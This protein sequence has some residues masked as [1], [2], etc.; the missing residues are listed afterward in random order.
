MYAR[1]FSLL[2]MRKV[3]VLGG[4]ALTC[5][6]MQHTCPYMHVLA[7]LRCI[8]STFMDGA[9]DPKLYKSGTL[10]R[11]QMK[12]HGKAK[13]FTRK[14]AKTCALQDRAGPS[15]HL[16]SF[17][18]VSALLL[19]NAHSL[20]TMYWKYENVINN[21]LKKH[22]CANIKKSYFGFFVICLVCQKQFFA[23]QFYLKVSNIC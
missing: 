22:M 3:K 7:K 21:K 14:Y 2:R 16:K 11:L 5:S 8:Q 6:C 9:T 13:Q 17:Q 20:L 15:K 18:Q 19:F 10:N 23:K 1:K 4:C 12:P